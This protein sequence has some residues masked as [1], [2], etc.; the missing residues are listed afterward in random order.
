MSG[1]TAHGRTVI[2]HRSISKWVLS[3]A[4]TLISIAPVT[5]CRRDR[6]RVVKSLGKAQATKT[7][8]PLSPV[9]VGA[10]RAGTA[11][12]TFGV[13]H[14]SGPTTPPLA[15]ARALVTKARLQLVD[16]V[17]AEAVVSGNRNEDLRGL[18]KVVAQH[19]AEPFLRSDLADDATELRSSIDDLPIQPLMISLPMV[20]LKIL[21]CRSVQRFL[22]EE[23]QLIQTFALE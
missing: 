23:D 21:P 6:A 5:A 14:M 17:P 18:S 15:L 7:M 2:L 22:T 10:L 9:P 20:M 12:M 11:V 4:V 3:L 16:A 19:S 8:S 13:Y 1:Q